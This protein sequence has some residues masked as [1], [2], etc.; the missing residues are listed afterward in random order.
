MRVY[1][2][3]GRRDNLFKSRIKILVNAL[4][5]DEFRT[6]VEAEW[7][8][9]DKPSVDLP[10]DEYERIAELPRANVGPQARDKG[11]VQASTWRFTQ[12]NNRSTL[13]NKRLF[14]VVTR[15]DFPW[16]EPHGAAEEPYALVVCLRD[17]ENEEARLY[18]E[19]R[20]RLQARA[21]AR[22]RT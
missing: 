19:L 6:Q 8:K 4:G 21:R 12:F 10:R 1:N 5:I 14:V 3:H 15:N 2:L 7:E 20:N 9:I 13:R 16:G 18:T 17:H 11:T 22:A